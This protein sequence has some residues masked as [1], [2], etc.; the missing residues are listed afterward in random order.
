M[1]I[2]PNQMMT[3][4]GLP[5]SCLISQEDRDKAWQA[6]PPRTAGQYGKFNTEPT[7]YGATMTKEEITLLFELK[8]SKERGA[9]SLSCSQHL[10]AVAQ[11]IKLGF[12][13]HH[14][15]SDMQFFITDAG[16]KE[17]DKHKRPL[18]Q[19]ALNWATT[20]IKKVESYKAANP[21]L[22]SRTKPAREVIK[23]SRPPGS[24]KGKALEVVAMMRKPGG[25]TKKE[26][27]K[28]I[29]WKAISFQQQAAQCGV[30]VEIDKSCDP[31]RYIVK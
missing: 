21:D 30:T 19:E 6:K 1:S 29:G 13:R 26:V 3:D 15:F 5:L 20:E 22:K 17:A 4:D 25:V 10:A 18:S 16:M 7:S 31:W 8:A 27:L 24:G 11:L 2:T 9:A 12:A 23:P 14:G 28:A